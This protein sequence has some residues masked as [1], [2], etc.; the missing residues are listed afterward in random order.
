MFD[1]DFWGHDE[2]DAGTLTDSAG[3]GYHDMIKLEVSA[4]LMESICH[5]IHGKM[6]T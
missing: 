3:P 4:G 6:H 2:S 5:M 1:A